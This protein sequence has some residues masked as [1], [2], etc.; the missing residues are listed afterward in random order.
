MPIPGYDPDDIV[1]VNLE[2]DGPAASIAVVAARVPE[3]LALERADAGERTDATERDA[4]P[5]PNV[6]GGPVRIVG[7]EDVTGLDALHLGL[8]YDPDDLPPDADPADLAVAVRTDAGY[9]TLESTVDSD[10]GEVT[11]TTTEQL[12]GETIGLV[13]TE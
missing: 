8:E 4:D 7:L 13:A 12:P 3:Q 2:D 6:V 10:A 11:A 5:S 1:E 9:E